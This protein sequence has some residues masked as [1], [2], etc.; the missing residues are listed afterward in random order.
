MS[1]MCTC[2]WMWDGKGQ[3]RN[4][5]TSGLARCQKKGKKEWMAGT[6]AAKSC[7]HLISQF[8][9]GLHKVRGGVH[10]GVGVLR[11]P[12]RISAHAVRE[13]VKDG[14]LRGQMQKFN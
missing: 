4:P 10:L 12:H 8:G 2:G 6:P 14:R 1:R 3:C 7:R 9:G 13:L 5:A 11:L